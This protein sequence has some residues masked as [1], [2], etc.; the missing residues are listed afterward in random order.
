MS[1]K[2]LTFCFLD[3]NDHLAPALPSASREHI[4]EL[5][6]P[7]RLQSGVIEP[8][9]LKLSLDMETRFILF[10]IRP[11]RRCALLVE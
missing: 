10:D 1:P 5:Q 2:G 6:R 4:R 3:R 9:E 8:I 11:H 7:D